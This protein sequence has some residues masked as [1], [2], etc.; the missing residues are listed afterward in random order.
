[1]K[2]DDDVYVNIPRLIEAL[3]NKSKEYI[4]KA[5]NS[6][7]MKPSKTLNETQKN[8]LLKNEKLLMGDLIC[9]ARPISDISS[10]WYFLSLILL[11]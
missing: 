3:Q 6:L 2:T 10:K 9:D 8:A 1:M 5:T 11:M 4:Q 7:N